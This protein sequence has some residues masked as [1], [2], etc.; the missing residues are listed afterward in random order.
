[1]TTPLVFFK[2]LPFAGVSAWRLRRAIQALCW[3]VALAGAGGVSAQ[4]RFAPAAGQIVLPSAVHAQSGQPGSLRALEQDW[5]RKPQDLDAA[6]RYARAVFVLGLTEGD[7]RWYGSAKAA[8][9]PWWDRPTLSAQGH[10]VRGLVHQGFHDFDAGLRDFNAAIALDPQQS[11]FWSWR[12]ALH[13]LLSDMRAAG[14]DCQEIQ[15]RFGQ[16]EADACRATL[17]YRTGQARQATALWDRLV[18]LPD[19]QAGLTQDWLRFHQGEAYR[20]LGQYD[21]AI[22]IWEQHLKARPQSHLVRLSLADLLNQ[23]GQYARAKRSAAV[24]GEPTD[25]LLMQSLLASQGLGDPDTEKLAAQFESRMQSQALRQESMIERPKMIY[26]IVYGRDVPAGLALA[27]RNW[28]EQNEPADAVLL[29]QAALKLDRPQ[30][31]APVL[32][33]MAQTGYTDALLQPLAQQLQARLAR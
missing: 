24:S 16:D 9:Q 27:E 15:R 18:R 31:A 7:L 33:W 5:R 29:V 12:F 26:L 6:L 4:P 20:T 2:P 14:E 17:L 10:F 22:A 23:Q 1:M 28:K 11:E 19:F 13:L 21:R 32:A 30:A 8:L 25:A 3:G